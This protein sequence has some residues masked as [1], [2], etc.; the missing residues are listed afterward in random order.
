MNS[1]N[2]AEDRYKYIDDLSVL[3][4]VMMTSI[5]REYDFY[6]HVGSE[7]GIDQDFL[8]LD[9]FRTQDK[10]DRISAWTAQKLIKLNE[11]KY[12]YM[13]FS[14]TKENFAT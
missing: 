6:Q 10:L 2:N 3:E 1:N 8:P 5:L 14:R 11:E 12:N 9:S 7:M 13:I 4:V